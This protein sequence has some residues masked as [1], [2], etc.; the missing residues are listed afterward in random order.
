M[1]RSTRVEAL[2]WDTDTRRGNRSEMGCRGKSL[3]TPGVS[4][5]AK[6]SHPHRVDSFAQMPSSRRPVSLVSL[7]LRGCCPFSSSR[8]SWCLK[9]EC[10]R[11]M[12][13]FPASSTAPLVVFCLS[14][15]WGRGGRA[16]ITAA[17]SH[18]VVYLK[19]EYC[20]CG[21]NVSKQNLAA[22]QYCQTEPVSL[23]S[24]PLSLCHAVLSTCRQDKWQEK[25]DTFFKR[26]PV[27]KVES[28]EMLTSNNN[29]LCH[30]DICD[31]YFTI[32]LYLLSID[33]GLP[34]PHLLKVSSVGWY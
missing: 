32:L 31:I 4:L 25:T 21:R 30:L 26:N 2:R 5:S 10:D 1:C 17:H 28:W 3:K 18:Q 23:S 29:W 8:T 9:P 22:S 24:R 7:W 27:S 20:L 12:T 6:S 19:S 13:G 14:F 16:S 34:A 11:L 15:S 33:W